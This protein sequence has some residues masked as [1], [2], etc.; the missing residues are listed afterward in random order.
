MRI[1]YFDAFAGISGDMT[2]GALADSGADQRLLAETLNSLVTGAKVRFERT[3]RA[4]LAATKFVV[5]IAD[6]RPQ[7]VRH[8]PE[9]LEL[10]DRASLPEPVKQDA[11]AIFR[12]LGEVEA[13]VHDIPLE[14]V[15]FHEVGA[16]D[17]IIDIV[18]AALGLHLLQ[19]DAVYCSPVNV[20]RGTVRTE[21]GVL[22][23]PAPATARL[24][25]N[26]PIYSQGPEFELTTPTG[27][28]IVSTLARAFGP[29][30]AVTLRAVGYG[31]GDQEFP[32]FPNV[33]RVLVGELSM[34]KEA[35]EV[36]VIEANIDDASPQLLA[37][38]VDQ[39]L[40]SGALDAS[41]TPLVMKK[42]RP[43]VLLR[44]ITRVEDSEQLAERVLQE[45]TSLGVRIYRAERRVR[46]RETVEVDTPYGKARV[47]VASDGSFA[48]EYEDCR[49]LAIASGV[50][51]KQ[52]LTEVSCRYWNSRKPVSSDDER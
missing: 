36:A 32:G 20:G 5:E 6:G 30:P 12:R 29:L 24:L 8:L 9:I 41:L 19:I 46:P 31:A 40:S 2:V 17:S 47:K 43:G 44:V 51:L 33:L 37:H 26:R 48:P 14:Q 45:T 1:C 35:T 4:G 25:E 16:I 15:H 7:R 38:A 52:I 13:A 34:A 42:G 18:G 50:P 28:A 49:R 22:P 39:L 10:I 27:A 23:V 11:S 21:H 3:R